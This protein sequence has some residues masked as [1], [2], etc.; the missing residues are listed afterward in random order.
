MDSLILVNN[1]EKKQYEIHIENVVARIEYAL[2][3]GVVKLQHT[4]V[5]VELKGKGVASQL[6]GLVLKDIEH[7]GLKVLPKCLFVAGYIDRHPD[8]K[9][10]VVDG[11]GV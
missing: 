3:G 5:P 11:H 4:E 6:V 8:W 7:R 1:T 9:R 2:V 10:V